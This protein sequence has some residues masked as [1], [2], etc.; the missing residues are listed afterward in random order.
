MSYFKKTILI[1]LMMIMI[2][3]CSIKNE[4]NMS[5]DSSGKLNYQVLL[6]FDKELL[7]NVMTINEYPGEINNE[8]MMD[9]INYNLKVP[10][11][12]GLVK[13]DY[14]ED[15]YIGKIFVY[16]VD[17]IND[18]SSNKKITINLGDFSSENKLINQ[19]LFYKQGKKYSANFV[20]NLK[21]GY[22]N[23]NYFTLFTVN[24]P[25]SASKNNADVITNNGKTLTWKIDN[26]SEKKIM[27]DFML[28]NYDIY[29]TI[30]A[31]IITIIII[32]LIIMYIKSSE[33]K[34]KEKSEEKPIKISKGKSKEKIKSKSTKKTKEKSEEKSTKKEVKK[35]K[36][37]PNKKS[38]IN[39]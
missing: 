11:L 16:K 5:I 3:G 39:N 1:F 29:Y 24:L 2:S 22:E 34:T 25:T 19:K 18:I 30:A 7:T 27:F 12:D 4:N 20:I 8:S 33:E 35:L 38:K 37:K 31:L 17:N 9:Y 23:V 26:T 36:E 14:Y 21:D 32:V 6:A 10:Y 13:K 28:K 15:N